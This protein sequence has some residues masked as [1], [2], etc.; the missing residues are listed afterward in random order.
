MGK[1]EDKLITCA[2]CFGEGC[3]ECNFKGKLITMNDYSKEVV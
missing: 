1:N 3:K 2:S